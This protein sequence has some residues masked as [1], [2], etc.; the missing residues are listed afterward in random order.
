ME[1][2]MTSPTGS[3]PASRT[4][5]NS[6]IERSLVNRPRLPSP[7]RISTRRRR[8]ASGSPSC[9]P[10]VYG[11][12]FFSACLAVGRRPLW[13]KPDRSGNDFVFQGDRVLDLEDRPPARVGGDGGADRREMVDH[14]DP[15]GVVD[16]DLARLR[17]DLDVGSDDSFRS[18]GA[19]L[20]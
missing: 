15:L 13:P 10:G 8:A 14:V 12:V 11:I 4:S 7:P 3:K 16:F 2:P 20:G 19:R 6:L 18:D 5:R 17:F 9:E 1:L